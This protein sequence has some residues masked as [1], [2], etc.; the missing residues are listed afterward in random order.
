M[1]NILIV[2]GGRSG[3]RF[4]SSY[5][6]DREINLTVAGF[7]KRNKT[8]PLAEKYRIPYVEFDELDDLSLFDVIIL[9][10]PYEIRKYCI[11]IIAQ[12]RFEGKMIVEKP[13]ATNLDDYYWMV[14]A[15]KNIPFCVPF[16]RRYDSRYEIK[17]DDVV[18]IKWPIDSYREVNIFRDLVPHCIDWILSGLQQEIRKIDV[19]YANEKYY[20][21]QINDITVELVFC[22]GEADRVTLN[23]VEYPWIDL[24]KVNNRLLAELTNQDF[25]NTKLVKD[26]YYSSRIM[27]ELLKKCVF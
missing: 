26:L 17:I 4:I 5:I 15:L 21:F 8:R 14:D 3:E 12:L 7:S 20:K 13:F 22:C 25:N 11:S 16:S 10:I 27:E 24:Y 19:L 23:D 2:G 9:S 1:I 6:F 18:C